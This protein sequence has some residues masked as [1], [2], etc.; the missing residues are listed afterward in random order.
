VATHYGIDRGVD[1]ILALFEQPSS[2]QAVTGFLRHAVPETPVSDSW[3]KELVD[4]GA[5]IPSP[6]ASQQSAPALL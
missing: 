1:S 3:F 2:I 6:R 4:I 5:L